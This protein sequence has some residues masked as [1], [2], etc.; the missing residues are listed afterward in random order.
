[1]KNPTDTPLSEHTQQTPVDAINIAR[2]VL[3]AREALDFGAEHLSH[4]I[5]E[6]LR[7]ARVRALAV[8]SNQKTSH[9][10]Q[11]SHSNFNFG[12]WFNRLS[13]GLR[14]GIGVHSRYLKPF[15]ALALV[16]KAQAA[17]L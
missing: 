1:M 16:H 5:T 17:I 10:T 15:A 11:S 6:R 4:D 3:L 7:V 2:S 14:G 9:A 12:Q 13:G 8:A